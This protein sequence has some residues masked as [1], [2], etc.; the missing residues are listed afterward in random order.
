MVSRG[1]RR[2]LVSLSG[3]GPKVFDGDGGYTEPPVSLSPATRFAEIKPATARDLE[4]VAAGTVM[5]TNTVLVS[6]DFHPSVN[7]KTMLAWT[8]QAGIAH[9]AAVTGVHNTEMRCVELILV[10]VE[11]VQ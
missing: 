10:A 7:T 8:D 1:A 4:R 6:M 2:H 11:V 3:P 9:S 5:S